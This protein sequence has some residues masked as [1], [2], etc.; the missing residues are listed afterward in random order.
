MRD[1]PPRFN[2]LRAKRVQFEVGMEVTELA[3]TVS[4][5]A[6]MFGWKAHVYFAQVYLRLC[7]V[8]SF[9]VIKM[10]SLLCSVFDCIPDG[11]RNDW[12][13]TLWDFDCRSQKHRLRHDFGPHGSLPDA[14]ALRRSTR[15]PWSEKDDWLLLAGN[16][17]CRWKIW[18]TSS[19][20]QQEKGETWSSEA[21]MI[22]N[23]QI[24]SI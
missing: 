24:I 2:I 18:N 21:W 3:W 23:D 1:L 20:L 22:W 4:Q 11:V 15:C 17:C 10:L 13:G 5:S 6:G 9:C 12:A 14:S 7:R 16:K 19:R 8:Q